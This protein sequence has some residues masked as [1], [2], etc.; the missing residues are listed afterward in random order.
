VRLLLGENHRLRGWQAVKA[1]SP[2]L[3]TIPFRVRFVRIADLCKLKFHL[4][5]HRDS[6]AAGGPADV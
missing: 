1:N 4:M 3:K 6:S 5:W 2:R